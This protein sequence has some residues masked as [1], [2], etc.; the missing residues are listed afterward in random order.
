[1]QEGKVIAYASRQLKPH[2]K[3]YP[4]HDL[5]LAAIVFVLK[6]LR[7]H[8]YG[9]RCRIFTDHKKLNLRQRRWLE[10]I[11]DYE[12]VIDYHPGK[13]NVVADAL[14]RK[15]LFA[16]RMTILEDASIL[17]GLRTRPMFLQEIYE[18]QKDDG[19]LQTKNTQCETSVE[20]DFRINLDGCLMF[21]DRVCVPRND[22]LIRKVLHETHNGCLSVHPGSTKMYNNLKQRYW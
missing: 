11:K 2:E 4:T 7:H 13:A 8:L 1:M 16:L 12:L 17:A 21:R 14:S 18:A 20:S 15:S 19:D 6:I 9:E 5:E 22:E 3:N 10:L